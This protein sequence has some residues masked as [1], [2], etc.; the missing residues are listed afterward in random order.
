MIASNLFRKPLPNHIKRQ[1]LCPGF[2]DGA[3]GYQKRDLAYCMND[4]LAETIQ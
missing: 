4:P 1:I 2:L 3:K